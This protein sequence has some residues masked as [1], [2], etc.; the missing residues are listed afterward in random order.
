M[1]PLHAAA[2]IVQLPQVVD[3]HHDSPQIYPQT[4]TLCP[5][6]HPSPSC[7]IFFLYLFIYQPF[8]SMFSD[9][10]EKVEK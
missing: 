1:R 5:F 10:R 9:G 2:A 6:F 7:L 4:N 3:K 8:H